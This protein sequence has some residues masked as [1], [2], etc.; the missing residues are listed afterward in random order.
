MQ[1]PRVR[2]RP[3]DGPGNLVL[4]ETGALVELMAGNVVLLS[5]GAL[6][7]EREFGRLTAT[8]GKGPLKRVVVGGL[9]FGVTLRGVLDVAPAEARV[10]VVEKVS[11]VVDLVRGELASIADHPLDDPRV[12][13][14]PGDVNDVLAE[15]D[16]DVDVILL[17]VDNG[18]HWASFRSNA[19]LYSRAGLSA[20]RRSLVAGGALAVWSGYAAD[21]FLGQL[22]GAGFV[23]SIVPLCEGERIR[24]RA[25]VGRP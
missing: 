2:V 1:R 25:Y 7:T 3:I 14:V 10:V 21:E 8:L 18:P 17:D 16:G 13:L 20:A 19:R 15:A 5:S 4:R 11:A 12:E 22:R 24:A 6:G 23:P 9:G